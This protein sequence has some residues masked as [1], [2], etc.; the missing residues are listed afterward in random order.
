[1]IVV[2]H[3]VFKLAIE[4]NIS[5]LLEQVNIQPL[6]FKFIAATKIHKHFYLNN[7]F[8]GLYLTAANQGSKFSL[9]AAGSTALL[10]QLCC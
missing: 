8:I 6:I 10:D 4:T 3:V 1:V 7:D 2:V 9:G 5:T